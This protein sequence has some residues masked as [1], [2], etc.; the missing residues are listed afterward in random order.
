MV[1]SMNIQDQTNEEPSGIGEAP[2]APASAAAPSEAPSPD[3]HEAPLEATPTEGQPKGL[4]SMGEEPMTLEQLVAEITSCTLSTLDAVTRCQE[5]H[6]STLQAAH[7]ASADD[8]VDQSNQADVVTAPTA[9]PTA[10]ALLKHPRIRAIRT[11]TKRI[12]TSAWVSGSQGVKRMLGEVT[13]VAEEARVMRDKA[14]AHEHNVTVSLSA[15]RQAAAVRMREV[16]EAEDARDATVVAKAKAA[17]ELAEAR[18]EHDNVERALLMLKKEAGEAS[19]AATALMKAQTD[20]QKLEEE[21][22]SM[23]ALS[24]EM[25][26]LGLENAPLNRDA[27]HVRAA[28]DRAMSLTSQLTRI[29]DREHR[30]AVTAELRYQQALIRQEKEVREAEVAAEAVQQLELVLTKEAD[31]A[32]AAIR[33]ENALV[34]QLEHDR[35]EAIRLRESAEEREKQQA[36]LECQLYNKHMGGESSP[37]KL[38]LKKKQRN[39]QRRGSQNKPPMQHVE[40]A[41]SVTEHPAVSGLMPERRA[42]RNLRRQQQKSSK[43]GK[44]KAGFCRARARRASAEDSSFTALPSERMCALWASMEKNNAVMKRAVSSVQG[45][46]SMQLPAGRCSTAPVGQRVESGFSSA[47]SFGML[48]S[49]RKIVYTATQ[50]GGAGSLMGPTSCRTDSDFSSSGGTGMGAGSGPLASSSRRAGPSLRGKPRAAVTRLKTPG[51]G[52]YHTHAQYAVTSN[53]ERSA[54]PNLSTSWKRYTLNSGDKSHIVSEE[55]ARISLGEFVAEQEP[56]ANPRYLRS[57]IASPAQ[58]RVG[59]APSRLAITNC[60]NGLTAIAKDTKF[61]CGPGPAGYDISAVAGAQP[62]LSRDARAPS[63]TVTGRHKSQFELPDELG[64]EPV[65]A[66]AGFGDLF[67]SKKGLAF[68][69]DN[70]NIRT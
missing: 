13:R 1:I 45:S 58:T 27:L 9:E 31:E 38:A 53:M 2:L 68:G 70:K 62:V 28:L 33:H 18:Q 61:D 17:K 60:G 32:E 29:A 48:H 21:M 15:R 47:R 44:R 8:A 66:P 57:V 40:F 67:N 30:E 23:Q 4:T 34:E 14:A 69:T 49:D 56:M 25:E 20:M 16:E 37:S 12:S 39:P 19:T 42:E 11:R 43:F 22:E 51:P 63:H 35:D 46:V 59:T 65:C 36:D 54:T 3:D 7:E 24:Q 41:C 26:R 52:N 55:T 10:E 6:R 5:S 50:I 64:L